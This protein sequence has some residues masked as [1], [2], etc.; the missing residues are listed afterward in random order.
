MK[1]WYYQIQ[2]GTRVDYIVGKPYNILYWSNGS[3]VDV[4]G[5]VIRVT[6]TYVQVDIEKED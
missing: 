1:V 5:T 3:L 4:R 2:E 6:S